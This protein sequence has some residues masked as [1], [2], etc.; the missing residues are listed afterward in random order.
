MHTCNEIWMD[1]DMVFQCF[2]M[3]WRSLWSCNESALTWLPFPNLMNF[4][5]WISVI[6]LSPLI[7]DIVV[8]SRSYFFSFWLTYLLTHLLP[9]LL[10]SL[11]PYILFTSLPTCF[12]TSLLTYSLFLSLHI[13]LDKHVLH[14]KTC[15]FY[16]EMGQTLIRL[17]SWMAGKLLSVAN[18]IHVTDNLKYHLYLLANPILTRNAEETSIRPACRPRVSGQL[19]SD[20]RPA[21]REVHPALLQ[22]GDVVHVQLAAL[23]KWKCG[24]CDGNPQDS[25]RQWWFNGIQWWINI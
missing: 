21:P 1:I 23:P 20:Q 6:Q 16:L 14:Q 19:R 13:F 25:Y 9:Y 10:T 8:Y 11:L 22:L 5:N 24:R 3:G 15:S 12:L 4:C 7:V 17:L 2:W 18:Y